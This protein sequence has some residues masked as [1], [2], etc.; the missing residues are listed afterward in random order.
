M[1]KRTAPRLLTVLF[2]TA[3]TCLFF[4]GAVFAAGIEVTSSTYLQTRENSRDE[5]YAPLFEYLTLGFTDAKGGTLDFYAAGWVRYDLRSIRYDKRERDEL[6]YAYL[7]Y[8]P[9]RDKRLVVNAGR[10]MV[11]GGVASELFDGLS[12]RWEVSPRNGLSVYGGVPVETETDTRRSDYLYGGR[13]YH[14][15]GRTAEVGLSYLKEENDGN[16]YREETGIDLWAFPARWIELQGQSFYNTLTDG[17]LDHSY[18]LRLF[19]A[20]NLVV[21]GIYSYTDFD[22][23]FSATTLSAFSPDFWGR[24][25]RM[26][27]AGGTVDYTIRPAVAVSADYRTY[28]Y[29]TLGDAAYYGAGLTA[30]LFD[31]R[32]GLSLHRMDGDA[33]NLKYLETRAYAIKVIDRLKLAFDVIN[34]HYDEAV[35]GLSNAYYLSGT[36]GY[37]LKDYATAWLNL[38]YG[39]T[40]DYRYDIRGLFRLA[41]AFKK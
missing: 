1:R 31:I 38:E 16:S 18:S 36:A 30:T 4:S 33:E 3:A 8:H 28:N 23:A 5:K 11:F 17:W 35:N 20:K 15:F 13:V 26:V 22:D 10:H 2:L 12:V 24:N 21:T 37:K 14:R 29:K 27:K 7:S 34:I 32:T 6:T 25:E 19:P 40:P 9:F 39:K 41:V